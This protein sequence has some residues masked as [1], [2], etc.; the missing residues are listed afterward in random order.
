MVRNVEAFSSL[1]FFTDPLYSFMLN[2]DRAT[3]TELILHESVH[4][5]IFVKGQEQFNEELATFAGRQGTEAYLTWRLGP[6]SPELAAY[7]RNLQDRQAF[8]TFLRGTAEQ[9]ALAYTDPTLD[10][11]GRLAAKRRIIDDRAALYSRTATDLV[12]S[13]SYRSFDMT[14]VD[15]A[16]LD[17]F[18]LYEEDLSAYHRL[19]HGPAGGDMRVFMTMMRGIAAVSVAAGRPLRDVLDQWRER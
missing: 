9:L 14:R 15:N 5:T 18:R 7:R 19:F 10:R 16:W 1:G 6:D 11:P 4:A 2:W 12:H 3:L 17:L 8:A 13:G